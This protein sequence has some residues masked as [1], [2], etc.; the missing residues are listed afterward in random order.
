M[1][2]KKILS[3]LTALSLLFTSGS[4]IKEAK[5]EEIKTNTIEIENE[6]FEILP[7]TNPF[8]LSE[9]VLDN[10][11]KYD[12]QSYLT[13]SQN[14]E[15]FIL[16]VRRDFLYVI[17]DSEK[18]IEQNKLFL[19]RKQGIL[20]S[21]LVKLPFISREKAKEYESVKLYS[22][23]STGEVIYIE[24]DNVYENY[25]NEN[26]FKKIEIENLLNKKTV[27]S[28]AFGNALEIFYGQTIEDNDI[29]FSID[30]Y[31]EKTSIRKLVELYKKIIPKEYWPLRKIVKLDENLPLNINSTLPTL[32]E[33]ILDENIKPYYLYQIRTEKK[34]Q[35][36]IS[37]YFSNKDEKGYIDIH[38]GEVIENT[39]GVNEKYLKNIG[40][41]IDNSFTLF[42]A[43]FYNEV[44]YRFSYYPDLKDIAPYF[45]NIE[46]LRDAVKLY[47]LMPLKYQVDYSYFDF[48]KSPNVDQSSYVKNTQGNFIINETEMTLRPITD[49]P[50]TK[51]LTIKG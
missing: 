28:F 38:T 1:N 2:K 39:K 48:K 11:I 7:I 45:T 12:N 3:Y 21:D 41:V 33:E 47:Q 17:L 4:F 42:P 29:G 6:E 15:T 40:I 10:Q 25:I 24:S 37:K 18:D 23:L 8:N 26:Y 30:T 36:V 14:N 19:N 22:D 32:K 31:D 43:S 9:E 27:N 44:S 35:F 5:S 49:K 46:T 16:L 13:I 34:V 50:K 51:E 20:Y